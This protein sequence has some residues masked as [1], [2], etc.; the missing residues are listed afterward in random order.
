MTGTTGGPAAVEGGA[1][2][3][4]RDAITLRA[5]LIM[6]GVLLLQLGF[7]LS[8]MGAFHAPRPHDVPITLVAPPEMRGDLAAR[9]DALPGDPLRVTAVADAAEARARL[10]DRRTDAALL[11][12]PDTR[13]DTLLVAS[14][15]GPSAT[16]A[17]TAVL[18]DVAR[19]QD[20]E[21]QVR[22]LRPPSAGDSRGLSSFY[23]VL[24]WTIG[25]YL[26]ASAL[27]M[28]AG[29]KRPTLHRTFVRLAAMIPYAF[30]SGIGGAVV[31]GP[32]LDCLPGAFWELVGI[33]TLVVFASGAVG[34]ALQSVAGTIGLGL[35]ILIFTVLGNP[36]SGGVY[37]ASLLPPFWAAI[38]Q[39]L[40][41]GAGTTVV[42]NTVYFD[43]HATTGALWILG[44]WAFGGV[45][46]AVLAAAL[47]ARRR[48]RAVATTAPAR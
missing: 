18:Q 6:L 24:S 2:E 41:P 46:V 37:P 32:V 15:G 1:R 13:L 26:A 39:A 3:E 43:G 28:A 48:P 33:G 22:D 44:A 45:V 42:R 14:A 7:A 31:V 20:R 19:T 8:Y 10:L 11:V 23:L 47:R 38:G 21:I 25:G 35:T 30:V 29:S 40:P 12:A 36:S 9:L 34:V 27:N 17:A 4:L 16:T 5:A